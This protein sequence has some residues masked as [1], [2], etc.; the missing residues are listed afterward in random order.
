MSANDVV[1]TPTEEGRRF[2][3]PGL[4]FRVT[5][6]EVRRSSLGLYAELTV[7]VVQGDL[8]G[9]VHWERVNLSRG[10]DKHKAV[11]TL[12][13]FCAERGQ[14]GVPWDRM[15]EVVRADVRAHQR[16]G[17]PFVRLADV[18]PRPMPWLLEGVVPLGDPTLFFAAGGAGKST[19]VAA[20]CYVIASGRRLGP[21][22][23][24]GQ[25]RPVVVCDWE[26]TEAEWARRLAAL[27]RAVGQAPPALVHYR[28][29]ATPLVEVLES[30]RGKVRAEGAGAVVVDSLMAALGG[31]ISPE[32]TSPFYNGLRSL[33]TDVTSLVVHHLGWGEQERA[34]G[35]PR[36]YGD[37]TITN[38]ARAAW[39]LVREE[40]GDAEEM[41]LTMTNTKMNGAAVRPS[42]GL[43]LLHQDAESE[44]YA[45]TVGQFDPLAAG[46]AN[47]RLGDRVLAALR[48]E[49]L[50]LERLVEETGA[51]RTSLQRTLERL[52]EHAV[53][54]RDGGG[55]G[56]GNVAFYRLASDRLNGHPDRG[57][58]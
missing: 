31:P 19:L 35:P 54:E 44:E 11:K 26:T 40:G 36:A 15:L 42:I 18:R 10:D 30:L 37:V 39:A 16:A 29:E 5:A 43:R 56:R 51:A 41:Q 2:D 47:L 21:F 27:A 52:V 13:A 4:G 55:R 12:A 23:L 49:P 7:E 45:I 9:H 38:R 53:V 22:R 58:N 25:P 34:A 3:W 20:L 6:S 33:G 57:E 24:V 32:F 46:S 14:T 28:P 48:G 1:V 50:N 8:V 17:A